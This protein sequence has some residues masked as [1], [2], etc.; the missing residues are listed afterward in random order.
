MQGGP[1]LI[2]SIWTG[3]RA[4]GADPVGSSSW[5]K[6]HVKPLRTAAQ[7]NVC[8]HCRGVSTA[9]LLDVLPRRT[10][11]PD[12]AAADNVG[13]L[14]ALPHDTVAC[15]R[16]GLSA[17]SALPVC[18][19]NVLASRAGRD[20]VLGIVEAVVLAPRLAELALV[21][22]VGRTASLGLVH[23]V[24]ARTTAA[25]YTSSVLVWGAVRHLVAV[26]KALAAFLALPIRKARAWLAFKVAFGTRRSAGHASGIRL[27]L[28]SCSIRAWIAIWNGAR[29]ARGIVRGIAFG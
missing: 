22:G 12:F 3:C 9:G 11:A 21:D 28:A 5:G 27:R 10:S 26:A 14:A 1:P 20:L 15:D 7:G 23:G 24:H 29:F 17:I 4:H 13:K 18:A 8:A 16:A 6:L 19:K 2:E 25:I